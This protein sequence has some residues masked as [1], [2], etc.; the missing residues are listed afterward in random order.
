MSHKVTQER[1]GGGGGGGGG[2]TYNKY[3]IASLRAAHKLTITDGYERFV[4]RC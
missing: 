2:L 1:R 4:V 3:A